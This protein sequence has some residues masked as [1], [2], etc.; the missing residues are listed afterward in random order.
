MPCVR[1]ISKIY[2]LPLDPCVIV[3]IHVSVVFGANVAAILGAD[4]KK[5]KVKSSSL[6]LFTMK[7]TRKSPLPE[8]VFGVYV[9]FYLQFGSNF[10]MYKLK[11]SI[12]STDHHFMLGFDFPFSLTWLISSSLTSVSANRLLYFGLFSWFWVMETSQITEPTE[13]PK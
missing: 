11:L 12:L 13:L 1:K 4:R 8:T 9:P 5:Y 3:I 2:H 7:E 10:S 6:R